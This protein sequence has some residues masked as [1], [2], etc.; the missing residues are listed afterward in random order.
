M[1]PRRPS[2]NQLACHPDRAIPDRAI[3]VDSVEKDLQKQ[4]PTILEN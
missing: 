1:R 3:V 2:A 4:W